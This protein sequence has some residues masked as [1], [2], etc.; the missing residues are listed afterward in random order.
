MFSPTYNI[1]HKITGGGRS[2]QRSEVAGSAGGRLIIEMARCA[3][4]LRMRLVTAGSA[5]SPTQPTPCMLRASSLW[6]GKAF[7]SVLMVKFIIFLNI[8]LPILC[9]YL[10]VP[11]VKLKFFLSLTPRKRNP[12]NGSKNCLL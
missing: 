10:F 5:H 3:E 12:E 7:Q 8:F 11:Y 6:V 4:D 9:C 2:D 1:C